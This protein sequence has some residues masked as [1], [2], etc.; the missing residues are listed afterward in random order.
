MS[1]HL[2]LPNAAACHT[3]GQ[4]HVVN[5]HQN[6]LQYVYTVINV[7]QLHLI[8]PMLLQAVLVIR[9]IKVRHTEKAVE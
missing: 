6:L 9:C 8:V 1:K 7:E 2:P 4:V 5:R 3:C